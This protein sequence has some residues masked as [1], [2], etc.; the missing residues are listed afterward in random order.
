LYIARLSP[1]AG[2]KRGNKK[3][4]SCLSMS[5]KADFL[6]GEYAEPIRSTKKTELKIRV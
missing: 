1:E 4:A 3:I 5:S 2:I 6:S